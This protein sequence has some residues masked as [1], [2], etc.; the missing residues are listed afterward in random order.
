MTSS[1][2]ASGV[3]ADAFARFG[4]A[5]DVLARLAR[6]GRI[7]PAYLLDGPDLSVALDAARTFAAALLC[8]D[9]AGP[10]GT[11]S[12]CR[13]VRSG[14]HPDLH[15]RGRDKATVIGVDALAELLER[16]HLAPM[17]GKRQVFVI[18][19]AE[20][21]AP[22]AVGKYLKTLEE[23][24]PTTTFLLVT[25]KPDRLPDAVRSRCQR[26][27]VPGR[28]P[29]EVRDALVSGGMEP[30]RATRLARLSEGSFARARRLAAIGA[31]EIADALVAAGLSQA[32]VA[33]TEV[34]RWLPE[35]RRRASEAGVA[36]E[37]A[38]ESGGE[39]LDEE[40]TGK[41][42]ESL[43]RALEDLFHALQVTARDRA[44]G[45]D[46]GPMAT[47]SREAAASALARWAHLHSLVRRNLNA[48]ALLLEAVS[49]LKGTTGAR[50]LP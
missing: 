34:E 25:E 18:A 3:G 30:V 16:A 27:R 43:R 21:M 33:G 8:P 45:G 14:T 13:R 40:G 50:R 32:P 4:P 12:T 19:P 42:A 26:V 9:P 44:A 31:D 48:T 17:E 39:S 10:C 23:P 6:G 46:E 29:E 35:L 20:A 22:E 11:C 24:P 49:A 5:G 38:G 2:S 36:A 28:T 37:T 15:L 47:V 1:S 7:A 41:D